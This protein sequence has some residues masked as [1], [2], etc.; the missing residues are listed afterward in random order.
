MKEII[1]YGAGGNF[2][3]FA[4]WLKE[5]YEIVALVDGDEKLWGQ[6]H[7]E[8]TVDSPEVI[9]CSKYDFI[10]VTPS[11]ETEIVEALKNK[12]HISESKIVA[13]EDL[14]C[15]NGKESDIRTCF[16]LV[17]GLG[18]SIINYNYIYRFYDFFKSDRIEIDIAN[19]SQAF[20]EFAGSG[21]FV[22]NFYGKDFDR[23]DYDLIIELRRYPSIVR[24]DYY[25][26]GRMSHKLTDYLFLCR[27]FEID[28]PELVLFG[29][30]NDGAGAD[31]EIKRGRKRCVQPDING[32]LGVEEKY[33]PIVEVDEDLLK[34]FGLYKEQYFTIH[35]GC[36]RF[37]FTN[38][39][40]K[41]WEED[42]Y[43]E[44]IRLLKLESPGIKI[45]LLGEE[46]ERSECLKD[47]DI[48]LLGKTNI[49]QLK[50]I[51]KY[52][53]I[54]VDTEGGLVHMRHA[55]GGGTS[56]VLF[57]PTSDKFFGYS[58]NVNIRTDACPK[59]CEWNT[60]DWAWNCSNTN[61]KHICMKSISPKRVI[62]IVKK[63]GCLRRL[64]KG[65]Y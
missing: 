54:H 65:R 43:E 34:E 46:Y 44:L 59:P 41:L 6:K 5:R 33:A 26:I 57:G 60:K 14:I 2:I 45:V 51:L 42:N 58:E 13:L 15:G 50:T 10:V 21:G 35:R 39:N 16:I 62:S 4:G 56:I 37:F 28:N 49:S 7:D 27:R 20:M 24:A 23:S 64:R 40:V 18:D 55:V 30:K 11:D 25:R 3:R 38:E 53:I 32:V 19:V 63:S 12:Y 22:K 31:K 48:D 36:D 17:G 9:I 29:P 47:C 52:S 61:N 8:I 1:I